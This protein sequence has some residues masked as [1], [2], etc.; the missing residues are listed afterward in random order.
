MEAF[1]IIALQFVVVGVTLVGMWRLLKER[2]YFH[3][4]Q[5]RRHH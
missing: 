5:V 2:D 1:L 3:D 4:S